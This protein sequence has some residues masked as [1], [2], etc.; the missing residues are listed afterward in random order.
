MNAVQT[1]LRS[2]A[3]TANYPT[4]FGL[5][6]HPIKDRMERALRYYKNREEMK[7]KWNAPTDADVSR[8]T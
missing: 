7:W 3:G 8:K 2:I 6:F 4:L 5:A 1:Q